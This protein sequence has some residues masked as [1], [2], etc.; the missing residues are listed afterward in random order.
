MVGMLKNPFDEY[1]DLKVKNHGSVASA[2]VI[3]VLAFIIYMVD[4]FGRSFTFRFVGS[5]GSAFLTTAVV[6]LVPAILWV[7][8]NYM[9]SAINDG[10]GTLRSVYVATAYSLTPY[11][12]FGPIVIASTYV[13]TLNEAVIVHYLWA[14][15]IGWSAFLI[16][17]SVKEIHNY[18][19]K[20]MVKIILLTLF[21]MIMA[22]IVCVILFLI[23][24]QVVLFFR[25]II[26]E[27]T[28]HV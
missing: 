22:I 11:V 7:L 17:L 19:V 2:T 4:M 1:Y 6:F 21:F 18:T 9:V 15:A 16:G 10:E 20:E 25:D 12:L 8:G 23:G 3:F 5:D 13:L 28:Y 14:I 24:Q 27:V 26:S